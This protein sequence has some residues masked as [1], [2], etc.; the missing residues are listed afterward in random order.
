MQVPTI[1]ISMPRIE[2]RSIKYGY[3]SARARAMKGDLI[4]PALMDEM[5]GVSSVE[6]M[7]ELLQKTGY[8]QDL[9]AASVDYGGSA[10]IASASSRNFA[11]TV[12][13][14]VTMAPKS[15]RKAIQALLI[16]WDLINIKTLLHAK[17]ISRN[18]EEVKH[19]L[20]DVGGLDEEDF[21]KIMR[22]DEDETIREIK[23]AGITFSKAEGD[24]FSHI[25]KTIDSHVYLQ[26]DQ[27]LASVGGK[28]VSYVRDI[29]RKEIDAK[30]IMIIER[31]KK[32]GMD[33]AKI[34]KHLIKGGTLSIYLI[35][36][37]I[38][39]KDLAQVVSLTKHKFHSLELRHDGKLTDMEIALERSVAALKKYG[40]NR[41]VL[42]LG[43]LIGFLLLKE[44]EINNLRKI[45]KAKE[46]K[47]AESDVRAMLV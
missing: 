11:R 4:K 34:K 10:L 8:R 44:E 46:Y 25:E 16:R 26:I 35:D 33:S 23:K 47:F 7:A 14:L 12:K 13:K 19:M 24:M 5:I 17:K 27:A 29:L 22:G 18:Y 31:L 30:N 6:A 2:S 38:E 9:A 42:S 21:R 40:F 45:A 39:A 41:D 20:Y 36:R 43:V 3:S 1:K 32:H 37:I 15:D 28:E